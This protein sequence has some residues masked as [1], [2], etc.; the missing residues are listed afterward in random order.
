MALKIY[1]S[2]PKRSELTHLTGDHEVFCV[3][4]KLQLIFTWLSHFLAL[5]R[6]H[7]WGFLTFK[8]VRPP[9]GSTQGCLVRCV[10]FK[11]LTQTTDIQKMQFQKNRRQINIPMRAIPPV[12]HVKLTFSSRFRFSSLMDCC[13]FT[14]VLLSSILRLLKWLVGR[15]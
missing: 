14:L 11:G 15:I 2:A 12:K 8:L 9:S 10:S 4:C 5:K 13:F 6:G 7:I 1:R 3:I